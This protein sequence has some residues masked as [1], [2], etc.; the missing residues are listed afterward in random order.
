MDQFYWILV[1]QTHLQ[2]TYKMVCIYSL[3]NMHNV[4]MLNLESPCISGLNENRLCIALL[5][6]V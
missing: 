1:Y 6:V 5:C 3:A 2:K 4:Y